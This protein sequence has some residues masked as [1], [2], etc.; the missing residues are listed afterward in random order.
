MSDNF[1]ID[2]IPNLMIHLAV[3][4]AV[5][6]G[7]SQSQATL[8][9]ISSH[10]VMLP[11]HTRLVNKPT[12]I[13]WNSLQLRIVV[14]IKPSNPYYFILYTKLFYYY[15]YS[16]VWNIVWVSSKHPF[17]FHFKGPLNCKACHRLLLLLLI[18]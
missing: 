2:Y 18:Q 8:K 5:E 9:P 6:I 13:T 12:I 15:Y 4:T 14:F 1:E 7:A 11:G 17:P 16:M 10:S 3:H